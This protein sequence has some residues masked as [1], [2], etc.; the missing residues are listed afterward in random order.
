MAETTGNLSLDELYSQANEMCLRHWGVEYT[1]TIELTNRN[2][3]NRWAAYAWGPSRRAVRM[4]R[5]TNARL[6]SETV[7]GNLL[8]ELVHWRLH[9]LGRHFGDEDD[10]FIAECIRVGAPLSHA[11]GAQRAYKA[12]LA[13]HTFEDEE[14]AV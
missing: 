1:G 11:K 7:L 9:T 2:W 14:A 8:H 5:K 13:K 10:D 3:K 4:S 12:Y 6:T